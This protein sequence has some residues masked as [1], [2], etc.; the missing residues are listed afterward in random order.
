MSNPVKLSHF[1]FNKIILYLTFS[2]I[3]TW[4][5]INTANGLVGLYLATKLQGDI[6][7]YVGA[8][9]AITNLLRAI[10]EIPIGLLADKLHQNDEEI[11]LAAGNLLMG[12]PFLFY[13]IITQASTYL[14]LQV[15]VGLGMGCNLVAWRKLFATNLDKGHEG[16]QYSAY[17]TLMSI[18]TALF[19]FF[20]GLIAGLNTHL[21]DAV[22]FGFGILMLSSVTYAFFI[23]RHKIK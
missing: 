1:K 2:D 19:G 7:T 21:F 22:M 12:L 16:F 17:D 15:L 10:S 4:G 23:Y 6:V 11:I 13:P 5:L 20:G 8:G 14:F 18:F 9:I 3:F